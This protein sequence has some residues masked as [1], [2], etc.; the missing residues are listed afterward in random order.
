[1]DDLPH[2]SDEVLAQKLRDDARFL[3]EIID[4]YE[5]KLSRYIRRKSSA[6]V[7]EVQDILQN[8]FMKVYKNIYDFDPT[9]SFSSWIYRITRNEIIDWYR[10]EKRRPHLSLEGTE[11]LM[12]TLAS[13]T[14]VVKLA[15]SKE[16]LQAIKDVLETF[17]E[18]YQEV[19]ELRFFEEKQYDEIAD[20]LAIPP[21][22]VAVRINR[23]KAKLKEK[24]QP[25]AR[26]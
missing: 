11:G 4:R 23:V 3:G 25:Y 7:D 21:G 8:V 15:S 13:E 24:L 22:T 17:P 18:M 9:L 20:I 12:E 6:D 5:Q 16:T 19:A 2:T 10:K 26:T 1:V 14:D